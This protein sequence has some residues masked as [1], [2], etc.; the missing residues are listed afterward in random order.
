MTRPT[1]SSPVGAGAADLSARALPVAARSVSQSAVLLLAR[2]HSRSLAWGWTRLV[3]GQRGVP[4]VPGLKIAKPLG[5]GYE[6]GFGLRP[7]LHRQGLWLGFDGDTAALEFVTR[8]P[9]VAAYREHASEFA[10]I[11]A[12]VTQAKGRWGGH[13][14]MPT[15][16]QAGLDRGRDPVAAPLAVGAAGSAPVLALTRASIRPSKV[17]SFW[18]MQPAAEQQLQRFPGCR[19]AVGLGEAPLLRQATISLWDSAAA[20]DA[21]ARS[22][23]HQAA[24]AAAYRGGFFSESMFLRM[25]PL[26]L[27]GQWKGL[28][29]G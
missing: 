16:A 28:S 18:R 10:C 15:P 29:L 8:S 9:W 25:R 2:W 19:L 20:M 21:Y 12:S 14:F 3:L 24:I 26:H 11:A 7:S 27:S 22:G 23:A 13:G 6:G 1:D 5:S 4:P 17:L